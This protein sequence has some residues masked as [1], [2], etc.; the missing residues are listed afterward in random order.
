V[1]LLLTFVVSSFSATMLC[2]AM[3]RIPGNH[4]FSLR[5]EVF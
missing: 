3:Q 5:Y 2:E 1:I 4:D